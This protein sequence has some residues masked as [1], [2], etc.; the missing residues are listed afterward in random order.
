MAAAAAA[1][2]RA[3]DP[4]ACWPPARRARHWRR[5]RP[6]GRGLRQGEEEE[7]VGAGAAKGGDEGRRACGTA[8]PR[9]VVGCNA[10]PSRS[11]VAAPLPARRLARG[12][13]S[14]RDHCL[15]VQ[16]VS[17]G[18]AG[19]SLDEALRGLQFEF[20]SLSLPPLP[21]PPRQEQMPRS[22]AR[23]LAQNPDARQQHARTRT[24]A[25]ATSCSTR[26]SRPSSEA[27][28]TKEREPFSS[29]P[30]LK[31]SNPNTP[32]SLPLAFALCPFGPSEPSCCP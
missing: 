11:R 26:P 1:A 3:W 17:K 31:K 24:N 15:R 8:R 25:R 14:D 5:R 6:A 2:S 12:G 28:S 13:T 21:S 27:T 32:L 22:L 9:F 7:G 4:P 19:R 16:G 23:P 30:P 29:L 18:P 10:C 20:F